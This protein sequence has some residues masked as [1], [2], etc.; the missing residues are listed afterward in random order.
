ML[1]QQMH[2]ALIL[3][4]SS[5]AGDCDW[6]LLTAWVD[7]GVGG[8]AFIFGL[9]NSCFSLLA[10]QKKAL[11]WYIRCSSPKYGHV[12]G[13]NVWQDQKQVSGSQYYSVMLTG[14]LLY[15]TTL[16]IGIGTEGGL[17]LH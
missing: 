12:S 3:S 15:L 1:L 7:S 8:D 10:V 9:P 16:Y 2:L 14:P 11:I 17:F 4:P 6:Q 13:Y 5:T